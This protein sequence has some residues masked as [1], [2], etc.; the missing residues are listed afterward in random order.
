[1]LTSV[2]EDVF[3]SESGLEITPSG[4]LLEDAGD[5]CD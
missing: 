3:V 4:C 1:M 5:D 2:S